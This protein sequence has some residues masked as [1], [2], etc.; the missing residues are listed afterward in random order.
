V[1]A[2][3]AT[4]VVLKPKNYHCTH[5]MMENL[6]DPSILDLI[7]FSGLNINDESSE[8]SR[9]PQDHRVSFNSKLGILF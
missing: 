8:Q 7:D 5:P 6:I 2:E 1:D 9:D 4:G 3:K